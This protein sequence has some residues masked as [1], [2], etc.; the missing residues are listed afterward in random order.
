MRNARVVPFV[1]GIC[2]FLASGIWESIVARAAHHACMMDGP[3]YTPPVL[4]LIEI[5]DSKAAMYDMLAG[6]WSI[7]ASEAESLLLTVSTIVDEHTFGLEVVK[8]DPANPNAA[9]SAAQGVWMT[10]TDYE[11]SR[12]NSAAA[13]ALPVTSNSTT[14]TSCKFRLAAGWCINGSSTVTGV[15]LLV[16]TMTETSGA[17]MERWSFLPVAVASDISAAAEKAQSVA[18][19]ING[20]GPARPGPGSLNGP[21]STEP[22]NGFPDQQSCIDWATTRYNNCISGQDLVLQ[23]CLAA[24]ISVYVA[25]SVGCL[26]WTAAPLALLACQASCLIVYWGAEKVCLAYDNQK[27][28]E[29]ANE[30]VDNMRDCGVLLV[31]H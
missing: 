7:S 3:T 19:R 16:Q 29:C 13:A 4:D 30:F 9:S 5:P 31:E 17:S 12:W 23:G 18:Q 2:C 21:I 1:I 10:Q 22:V 24:A 25:C 8:Y 6:C 15:A 26:I 27:V 14:M 20:Q 28:R 11:L